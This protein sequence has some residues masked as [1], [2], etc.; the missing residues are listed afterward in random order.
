VAPLTRELRAII[1]A[2]TTAFSAAMR[3][4]ERSADTFAA[5][6]R[7]GVGRA[8]PYAAVGLGLVA[9]QAR[10]GVAGVMEDEKALANLEATL[11]S[12][13]NAANT[14]SK[15]FFAF[16]NSLQAQT[17]TSAAAITQGAALLGTFK[18]IRN[19]GEGVNA[20]FD[21]TTV[22]ALDLSKKGYGSLDSANKML[23]KA[24]ND[25]VK[26]LTALGKAGVGFS[27]QQKEQIKTLVASGKTLEAQKIILG[28]VESQVGGT[29]KAYGE[30]TAGQLE[31]GKRAWEELQKALALAL[32]PAIQAIASGLS[33]LSGFLQN[34]QTVV[35][36][37]VLGFVGLASAVLAVNAAFSVAKAVALLANPIGLVIVAAAA[38]A[39]GLIYL[40]KN[41]ETARRIMNAAFNAVRAVVVPAINTVKAV[42]ETFLAFLRGDFR[43]VI[44]GIKGIV[45]NAFGAI[46][47][48]IRAIIGRVLSAAKDVGTAVWDGIKAGAAK[49]RELPGWLMSKIRGFLARIP[50]QVKAA[51]LGVGSAVVEGIKDGAAAA[52]PSL[53]SWLVSKLTSGG[54]LLGLAKRAIKSGSPSRLFA[55][56]VGAP[57][58]QGIQMGFERESDRITAS[59]GGAVTEAIRQARSNLAG[60]VGGL[61]S[62][63]AERVRA[64]TRAAFGADPTSARAQYDRER[65]ARERL[66]I[67]RQRMELREAVRTAR[68]RQDRARAAQALADF[69]AEQE[70]ARLETVARAE[71]AE[72]ARR[73][74]ASQ[75]A[76]EQREKDINNLVAVFNRGQIS[77]QEFQARLETLIGGPMGNEL[78]EAFSQNFNTALRDV[79]AQLAEFAREV[80]QVFGLAPGTIISPA[81]IRAA[82]MDEAARARQQEDEAAAAAA[83]A[84]SRERKLGPWK[85]IADRDANYSKLS[86]AMK[87]RATKT[88]VGKKFGITIAALA[89]GGIIRRAILAGE[90]G[91]EAVIP[92][93]GTAGR[94]ALARAMEDA[95]DAAGQRGPT[96]VLNVS[97]V[98]ASDVREFARR[99]KPE[100]DRVLVAGF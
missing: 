46:P 91:P 69:E 3:K 100:L 78:G 54:G 60:M 99:L 45:S 33:R 20:I 18:N 58:A 31:R 77:A 25:P 7:R 4:G 42:I 27:D 84:P 89:D 76:G 2:N 28:E 93:T 53:T 57:I 23:G 10:Q 92:L 8:A 47:G 65:D 94:N 22:A 26:G 52:W 30:T 61:A 50:G 73:D 63:A 44:N 64:S 41:S 21:R 19:E 48:L 11:K 82:L 38:L 83:A 5:K 43:G 72:V 36:A 86:P 71:E 40:Y 85:N 98:M 96:I 35:K 56:E 81:N 97:G 68:T 70:L 74:A 90:A 75:A 79:I 49:L 59:I 9:L 87:R 37:A 95:G 62:M 6:L 80:T 1:T 17:G 88:N 55:D 13:G 67:D 15:D 34:N 32:L 29:A 24:L 66:M 51:F 12:T 14:T 16:A 39:A